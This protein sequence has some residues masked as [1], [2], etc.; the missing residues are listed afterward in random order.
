MS[1]DVGEA[2]AFKEVIDDLAL[3]FVVNCPPEE[4]ESFERLLFQ[5]EAAF[6]FYEDQY[7]EIWPHAFPVLNLLGFAEKLFSEPP[8]ERFDRVIVDKKIDS[9]EQHLKVLRRLVKDVRAV[10]H[11]VDEKYMSRLKAK[12]QAARTRAEKAFNQ[13]DTK[14]QKSFPKFFYKQKVIEEMSVVAEN[15]NE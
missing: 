15:V 6:W 7:R 13:N 5:V 8:K 2:A 4:Q 11:K 10:D 14:L 12:N 1:D 3:R 9:R